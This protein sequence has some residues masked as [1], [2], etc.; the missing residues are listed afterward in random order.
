MRVL[1]TAQIRFANFSCR[2]CRS[3]AE[4]PQVSPFLERYF[5]TLMPS[6]SS[7]ERK[8]I[9]A[10]EVRAGSE[11][12]H[13]RFVRNLFDEG[14][15]EAAF[16]ATALMYYLIHHSIDQPE[17]FGRVKLMLH[18]PFRPLY[19]LLDC[20]RIHFSSFATAYQHCSLRHAHPHNAYG[21]DF[22][23]GLKDLFEEPE[24]STRASFVC[25]PLVDFIRLGC[26][27]ILQL[28][29]QKHVCGLYNSVTHQPV[30]YVAG[31]GWAVLL[32]RY[33]SQ[34]SPEIFSGEIDT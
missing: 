2:V 24:D 23:D 11:V 15:R 21:E 28:P 30:R 22:G 9:R 31:I 10:L 26:Y 13:Q 29:V 1:E 12:R 18:H 25:C 32:S 6:P 19:D 20:D 3:S 16:C 34:I 7:A 4:N 5:D 27:D 8:S 14:T 17:D 33:K